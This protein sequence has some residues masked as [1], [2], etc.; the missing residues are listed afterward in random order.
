MHPRLTTLGQEQASTAA[1]SIAADLGT[2]RVGLVLTSDL[3]RAVETAE[4]LVDALGG[5]LRCDRR[6]REQHLGIL[7]GRSHDV[8]SAYAHS[9]DWS[10][11]DL[12]FAGG[13]SLSQVHD[14]M[15]DALTSLDRSCV[16]IVV[17]HGDAIRAAVTHL[18]GAGPDLERWDDVPNG[19][20]ARIGSG[21]VVAWL[22]VPGTGGSTQDDCYRDSIPAWHRSSSGRSRTT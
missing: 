13:E 18:P 16:T 7:Q 3:V 5:E 9:H 17:S 2:R 1:R 6:L 14:R 12:P 8:T 4:I 11:P 10:D 20:V 19:A 15:A 22:A 21:N